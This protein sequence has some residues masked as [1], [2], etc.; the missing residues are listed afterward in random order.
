MARLDWSEM[1]KG[2]TKSDGI[3]W[4]AGPY[5]A[6]KLSEQLYFDASLLA[7]Q[8]YNNISP[9]GTYTD[10]FQTDRLQGHAKLSGKFDVGQ[11]TIRPQA[12]VV[13]SREVQNA[14]TD[15]MGNDVA[16]Q[17]FAKGTLT[18]GPAVAYLIKGEGVDY[19]PNVGLFGNWNFLSS[20][21]GTAFNAR[22][23]GGIDLSFEGGA[24]FNA[25][26][27]YGGIG[28]TTVAYGGRLG[29]TVPLN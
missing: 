9:F 14:Y 10:Q 24:S 11:F 19:T 22:V 4:V 27:F 7:G 6:A 3:G 8:S 5:V 2:N 23:E 25:K 28:S 21:G 16:A 26:A 18:L 15:G 12:G 20:G 13:V 17:T 29:L 1:T